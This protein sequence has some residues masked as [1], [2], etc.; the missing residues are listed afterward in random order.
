MMPKTWNNTIRGQ[1]VKGKKLYEYELKTLAAQNDIVTSPADSFFNYSV[2]PISLKVTEKFLSEDYSAQK[3]ASSVSS[4]IDEEMR[5]DR[6]RAAYD[7]A[8]NDPSVF[9][10]L[11]R[12]AARNRAI[13]AMLREQ[14]DQKLE[15]F[16]E[17]ENK[18]HELQQRVLQETAQKAAAV[19]SS[20]DCNDCVSE[21]QR[22]T[23]TTRNS[24]K[25]SLFS[26]SRL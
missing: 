21:I 8:D 17:T 9:G 20:C 3:V 7:A 6:I 10:P 12:A 4:Q 2:H 5:K 18:K 11:G 24:P 26:H 19:S 16:I 15:K 25:G 23:E 14:I 22:G 13:G 1:A